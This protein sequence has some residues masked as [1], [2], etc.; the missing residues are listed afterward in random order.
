MRQGR[1]GR[2]DAGSRPYRSREQ[3]REDGP[4]EP[5]DAVP[6]VQPGQE[7]PV[8]VGRTELEGKYRYGF[9]LSTMR[10]KVSVLWGGTT[11]L[12]IVVPVVVG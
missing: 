3:R 12:V 7:R 8:R 9:D 2:R 5:A 6:Y 1:G 4:G 10:R 11:V